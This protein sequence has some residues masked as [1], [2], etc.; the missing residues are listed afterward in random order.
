MARLVSVPNTKAIYSLTET[1]PLG[2]M[3]ISVVSDG[4]GYRASLTARGE[5][6]RGAG[7]SP[8]LALQDLAQTITSAAI[9]TGGG[10]G[11]DRMRVAV[12]L[13]KGE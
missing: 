6:F 13:L 5:P 9:K 12:T 10:R 7:L 3:T 11:R 2:Q 8:V 4:K 1:M